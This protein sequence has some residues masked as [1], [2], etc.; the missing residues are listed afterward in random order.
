M[1]K[2]YLGTI[3]NS[4]TVRQRRH[5]E[6]TVGQGICPFC[7]LNRVLNEVLRENQYW[8]IWKNPFKYKGHRDH[9]VIATRAHWENVEDLPQEVVLAWWDMN[10]WAIR[11][12]SLPGGGFVMRFGDPLYNAST[13][14]HIHSHVQVPSRR[15]MAIAVFHCP[16][17]H[18]IKT[19]PGK[20]C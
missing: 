19:V 4:R 2:T 20:L 5:M 1:K 15:G 6:E 12:F 8:R 18:I 16:R 11:E 3:K 7:D 13:L 14:R 17:G 10:I 9:L